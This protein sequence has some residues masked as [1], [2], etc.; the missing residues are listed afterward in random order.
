MSSIFTNWTRAAQRDKKDKSTHA[1]SKSSAFF[2]DTMLQRFR[3]GI[4]GLRLA[5][6]CRIHPIETRVVLLYNIQLRG[7]RPQPLTL[8]FFFDFK[9]FLLHLVLNLIVHWT[10]PNTWCWNRT[11]LLLIQLCLLI[12]T[13]FQRSGVLPFKN[14]A[15]AKAQ[16]ISRICGLPYDTCLGSSRKRLRNFSALS[17]CPKPGYT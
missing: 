10:N 2:T 9:L 7:A 12:C 4:S 13:S 11:C 1:S 8:A 5:S 15:I 3:L 6:D 14:S 17:I 16:N